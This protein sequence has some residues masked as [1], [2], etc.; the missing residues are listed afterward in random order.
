MFPLT[1]AEEG[2]SSLQFPSWFLGSFLWI[3]KF[4]SARLV[5]DPWCDLGLSSTAPLIFGERNYCSNS[6]TKHPHLGQNHL[7]LFSPAGSKKGAVDFPAR[8]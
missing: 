8:D 4:K 7:G 5:A 6:L 2:T 1:G 3:L